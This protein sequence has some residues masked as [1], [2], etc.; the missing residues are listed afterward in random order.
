MTY[1]IRKCTNGWTV[2]WYEP[3]NHRHITMVYLTKESLMEAMSLTM[4]AHEALPE[5]D[6]GGF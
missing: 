4:D 5:D 3:I 6:D 2:R 1:E